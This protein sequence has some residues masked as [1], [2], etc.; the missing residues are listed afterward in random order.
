MAELQSAAV[1]SRPRTQILLLIE[2][3]NGCR[4]L[5]AGAVGI[6]PTSLDLETNVLPLDDAPQLVEPAGSAPASPACKAGILL[7]E[8]RSH[9]CCASP[10]F[11]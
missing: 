1:P 4:V 6:E 5:L 2:P 8:L 7:V 9:I 3:L 10:A 11:W